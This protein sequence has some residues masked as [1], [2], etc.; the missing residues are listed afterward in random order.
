MNG[1]LCNACGGLLNEKVF[2]SGGNAFDDILSI[3]TGH[4][5]NGVYSTYTAVYR[6][7]VVLYIVRCTQLTKLLFELRNKKTGD[8]SKKL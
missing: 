3:Y 6:G 2:D 8:T 7:A 5:Q 4:C 1:V